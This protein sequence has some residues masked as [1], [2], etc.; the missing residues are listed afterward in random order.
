MV[1]YSNN[2][3]EVHRSQVS[4][5]EISISFRFGDENSVKNCEKIWYK[6]YHDK[7]WSSIKI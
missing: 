3:T 7:D 5:K 1:N 4:E 2:L 6:E